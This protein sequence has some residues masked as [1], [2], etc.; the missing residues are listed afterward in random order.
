MAINKRGSATAKAAASTRSR[1]RP[2]NQGLTIAFCL[3]STRTNRGQHRRN[4]LNND[5]EQAET[6]NARAARLAEAQEE[7]ACLIEEEEQATQEETAAEE[8]EELATILAKVEQLKT[9]KAEREAR[10]GTPRALTL[11]GRQPTQTS[12]ASVAW[13]GEESLISIELSDRYPTIDES[14]FKAIKENKFKPINVVKLTTDFVMDRSKVKVISIGSDVAL[15]ARKE[16][17]LSGELKG[18]PHLIRCFLIY[19]SI[20]LHFTHDSLQKLLRI[21]MLAYVEQLWIFSGAY[22]FDSIKIYH[23]AFHTFRIRQGIDDGALWE[24]IDSNLERRTMKLKQQIEFTSTSA[25]KRFNPSSTHTGMLQASS[26]T[27]NAPSQFN[28]SSNPNFP[29]C[30]R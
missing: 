23:M 2:S 14:H 19:M 7:E 15:E 13:Q 25:P 12:L 28:Q 4:L 26:S 20:L 18:L 9:K 17:A 10:Q 30:H 11:L 6:N 21:G 3:P 29:T 16:D 1:G 8:D 24:Q 27:F 22:T 5:N